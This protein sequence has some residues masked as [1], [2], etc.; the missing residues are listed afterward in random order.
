MNKDAVILPLSNLQS[1][2][3]KDA[4]I[5]PLSNLTPSDDLEVVAVTNIIIHVFADDILRTKTSNGEN[6]RLSQIVRGPMYPTWRRFEYWAGGD[7]GD[8]MAED[9]HEATNLWERQARDPRVNA[10]S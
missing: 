3:N 1:S 5:L 4:V 2:M 10:I 8:S 9:F 6:V 7:E